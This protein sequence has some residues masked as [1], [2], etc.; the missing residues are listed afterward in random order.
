[1]RLIDRYMIDKT[2]DCVLMVVVVLG[3]A[4]SLGFLL[5]FG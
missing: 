2:I 3:G 1:V 4:W 5:A